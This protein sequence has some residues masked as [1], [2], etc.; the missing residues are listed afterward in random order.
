M[1]RSA[2]QALALAAA[3]ALASGA[4]ASAAGASLGVDVSQPVSPA[5]ASCLAAANRSFAVVR[6]WE[7][8][9]RFDSNA[10]ATMA[11]L[12]GA[13]VDVSIYM[14]PCSFQSPAQ[15]LAALQGNLT[16]AG[17]TAFTRMWFDVETNPSRGCEWS[18][19]TSA[20][21]AYM[22]ALVAAAQAMPFFSGRL[23]IYT[24]I[25]MWQ[26]TWMGAACD[27]GASLPLWY[28]HYE[29]PPNPSFSDFVS[30][31]GWAAPYMKQY[32][33]GPPVC[34]DGPATDLNWRPTPAE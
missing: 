19:N 32:A 7:S 34:A 29:T 11:A 24:S 12:A 17:R 4:G 33:D 30:F 21:C 18:S 15:Q 20:N 27:V 28:P 22:G 16:A 26:N 3:A 1:P 23:G 5:A 2:A 9:G 13:G 8:L 6:A 31:G 10:P 25:H 14:F